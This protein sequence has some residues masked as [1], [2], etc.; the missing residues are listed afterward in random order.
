VPAI[1]SDGWDVM[2]P[3]AAGFDASLLRRPFQRLFSPDE[4]PGARSLIVARD[5]RL[6]AEGYCRSP[7]DIDR[8]YDIMSATKSVTSLIFGMALDDGALLGEEQR[9]FDL[10]PYE[11]AAAGASDD[12]VK[13]TVTLAHLLTMRSGIDLENPAFSLQLENGGIDDGVAYVL[14]RPLATRPGQSFHYRD[15]DA[16]LLGAALERA[17]A[18][19]LS[20]FAA[21]RLFGPLGIAEPRWLT[22]SG[23]TTYGA[24]G[25][26]LRP[27]DLAKIGQLVLD[28]GVWRG[29]RLISSAWLDRSTS[30]QLPAEAVQVAQFAYG[31]YWWIRPDNGTFFAWGHGG[32]YVYVNR[33]LRL[34]VTMTAEPDAEDSPAA[35]MP[36]QFLSLVDM[37]EQSITR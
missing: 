30:A 22:Q 1:R 19:P 15:A 34:L 23:R 13:Q 25:L 16:F 12:A 28:G 11:F 21:D 24:F 29:Q 37:I 18:R 26:F 6:V 31:Y 3:A 32:Q 9:L 33:T 2:T 5:G 14:G 8:A 35:V 36:V 7:E 4:L 20:A 17:L 27:R 10:L